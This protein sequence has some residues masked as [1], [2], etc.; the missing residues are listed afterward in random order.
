MNISAEIIYF[1]NHIGVFTLK[2][3]HYFWRTRK[4]L[5]MYIRTRK[6]ESG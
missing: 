1:N 3:T 4:M 2:K 6:E 5:N